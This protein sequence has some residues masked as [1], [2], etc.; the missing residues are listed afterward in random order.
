[1][2]KSPRACI[3]VTVLKIGLIRFESRKNFPIDQVGFHVS[4]MVGAVLSIV[5]VVKIDH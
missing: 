4:D 5:I 3:R 1:M 2:S